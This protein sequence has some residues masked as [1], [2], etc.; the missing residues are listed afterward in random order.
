MPFPC[1]SP[2]DSSVVTSNALQKHLQPT[3]FVAYYIRHKRRGTLQLQGNYLNNQDEKTL[4][5]QW[6][7]RDARSSRSTSAGFVR[8]VVY[9]VQE[10]QEV[11]EVQE[12]QKVEAMICKIAD[13]K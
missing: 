2:T 6:I 5:V 10:A 4:F 7:H 12:F 1:T 13:R 9:K 3:T 8:P 11:Q